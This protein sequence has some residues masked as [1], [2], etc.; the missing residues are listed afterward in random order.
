LRGHYCQ[1]WQLWPLNQKILAIIA[2]LIGA[3]KATKTELA[4]LPS[5]ICIGLVSHIIWDSLITPA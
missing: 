2:C 1:S 3:L 5:I 4:T